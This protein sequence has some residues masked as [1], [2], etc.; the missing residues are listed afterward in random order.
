M[1]T[2][3]SYPRRL[4]ILQAGITHCVQIFLEAMSTANGCFDYE[5]K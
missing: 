4:T 5:D 2:K 3:T 1:S